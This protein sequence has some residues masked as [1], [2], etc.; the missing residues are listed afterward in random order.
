LQVLLAC[1]AVAG[2]DVSPFDIRTQNPFLQIYG[3]PE[4][5]GATLQHPGDFSIGV[6][7][8][9]ANNAESAE[10]SSESLV[11]DGET[12]VVNVAL[13]RGVTD[14]L[15]LGLDVPL[16]THSG[17]FLDSAIKNWHDLWGMSNSKRNGSDGELLFQYENSEVP[18][19]QISSSSSGIG[20]VRFSAAV[21]LQ[22]GA[23]KDD[24]RMALR[25]TVKLPT[26]DEQELRG[27]G[28]VDTALAIHLENSAQL[29]GKQ[30]G[31]TGFAGVLA[32][33]N[34]EVLAVRQR[35]FAPFGGAALT[36]HANQRVAFTGQF[37]AHGAC[38]DSE[39]DELGGSSIQISVGGTYRSPRRRWSMSLALIEDLV[40]DATPDMGLYL[41]FHS[42]GAR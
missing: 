42:G 27:S 24:R 22:F 6:S 14:W 17:G 11:L 10:S 1:V 31:Y 13:R 21:P 28:A 30:I 38:I 35:D 2:A 8:A 18:Q 3:L 37:Q 39:L 4:F 25:L 7:L 19:Y 41:S 5:Q 12:Y 34:G 36:W 32:L 40:S 20:D 26:G 15:E 9:V 29:F 23:N 16:I 33:G